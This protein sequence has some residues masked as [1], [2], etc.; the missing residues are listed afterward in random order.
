MGRFVPSISIP[1]TSEGGR[2]AHLTRFGLSDGSVS[3]LTAAVND[4]DSYGAMT[5]R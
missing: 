3:W 1:G 5:T 2:W 4:E